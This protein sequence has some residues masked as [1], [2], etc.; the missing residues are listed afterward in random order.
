MSTLLLGRKQEKVLTQERLKEL[1]NYDMLSGNFTYLYKPNRRICIGDIAGSFAGK[2]GY[3]RLVIYIDGRRYPAHRLAWLYMT[4]EFPIE[5][6]DHINR[7]GLDNSWTN[8][9]SCSRS[10]NCHN[11]GI[12]KR[13]KSGIKGVFWDSTYNKW[14]ASIAIKSKV[15]WLGYFKTSDEAEEAV[16]AARQLLHKEFACNGV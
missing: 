9:R 8:L 12:S 15:K 10:Q 2:E 5:E 4:G 1:F 3:N 6:I 16:E 13:N 11:M 14:A 7:N